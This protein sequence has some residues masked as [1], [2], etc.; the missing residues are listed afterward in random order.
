MDTMINK[1]SGIGNDS[2]I[3]SFQCIDAI[4]ISLFIEKEGLGFYEKAAKNV[5]DRRVKDIFLR[6]AEEEREHIQ[7]LQHKLQFLKPVISGRG[8]IKRR[9]DLFLNEELKGKIFPASESNLAKEI[10]NDLE[11]LDYGIESEKRSIEILNSL[12]LNEKKL[13]VKSVFAHLM[14]EEK[15]HLALLEELKTKI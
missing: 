7:T 5:S 12:L 10:K 9:V 2:S 3:V 13:D 8:K 6:L 4:E 15:K 1:E 11:A 14:V